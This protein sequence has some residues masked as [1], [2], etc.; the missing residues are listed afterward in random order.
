M[1]HFSF[2][3]YLIVLG[4]LTL[5]W[6]ARA[7]GVVL[8]PS[9]LDA[10][11]RTKLERHVAKARLRAPQTF[12]AAR[13]VGTFR[14]SVAS[15]SRLAR[16]SAARAFLRLGPSA[17]MP[18]VELVAWDADVTGLSAEERHAFGDGLLQ[19]LAFARDPRVAPVLR[20][21]FMKSRDATYAT[22]AASGLG[23]LCGS[24]E[25][26]LLLGELRHDS[27][28]RLAALAGLGHCRNASVADRLAAELEAAADGATAAV[29]ARA[30][31]YIGSSW[32]LGAEHK[33]TAE[34]RAI[35]H[36]A[37][38]ALVAALRRDRAQARIAVQ[39]ALLM[40]ADESCL[41]SLRA[42]ERSASPQVA[43]D[44]ATIRRRLERSLARERP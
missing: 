23:M 6:P 20:A 41:P 4:S 30:L 27:P 11:A 31:G 18:M 28:R 8:A 29:A 44:A 3:A 36:R 2:I 14:K 25:R 19:A 13:A 5:S 33:S 39:R 7:D 21:V 12:A 43:T 40:V 1:K 26:E 35:R 16:P 34:A 42:L 15:R 24:A 22:T 17:V 32:A 10:G 38:Q 37:T 9:D